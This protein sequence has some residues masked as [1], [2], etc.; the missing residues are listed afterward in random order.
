MDRVYTALARVPLFGD[1]RCEAIELER[2]GSL[3][4]S[5]Y[6][7][8]VGGK[9]YVLRLPGRGTSEYIDRAAEEHNAR[10]ASAAGINAEVLFFDTNGLMLSRFVE[11]VR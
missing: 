10:I 1:A 2:L 9:A 7:V 4:N 11:G 3:T 8:T 5:I 6:K